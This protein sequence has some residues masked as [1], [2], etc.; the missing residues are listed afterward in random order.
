MALR[1]LTLEQA[2]ANHGPE[3]QTKAEWEAMHRASLLAEH[4]AH[5]RT[6]NQCAFAKEYERFVIAM[7]QHKVATP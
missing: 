3:K 5:I 4:E 2:L 6:H 1:N 7:H